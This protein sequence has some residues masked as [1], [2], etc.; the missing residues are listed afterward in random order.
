ME[1]ALSLASLVRDLPTY[2]RALQTIEASLSECLRALGEIRGTSWSPNLDRLAQRHAW[3]RDD[4]HSLNAKSLTPG[5][6]FRLRS[7]GQGLGC[8]Y[9]V[10]GS[11]LGGLV[12]YR[13]VHAALGVT[14]TAGGRYFQG[15]GRATSA[16]WNAFLTNLNL[17]PADSDLGDEAEAGALQTFQLFERYIA[18]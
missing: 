13:A 7:T 12:I 3:L 11:A 5:E 1:R 15:L 4:L 8:L 18:Q 2:T 16:E 17:I 6:T 9:V 10:E 14:A